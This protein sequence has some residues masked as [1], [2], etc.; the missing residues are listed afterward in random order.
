MR[1][2][3]VFGFAPFRLDLGSERLWREEEVVRLTAKAFAVLCY[4]VEQAGKLVT[5]DELF[6][7][8]WPET[9]VS[10][11]AL[12]VCIGEI[13]R[14]LGESAQSPRF[15]ET[16][17]GRGYRFLALV[18]LTLPAPAQ[19]LPQRPLPVV[20]LVTP[21]SLL[22]G[23]EAE[24]DRLQQCWTQAQQGTRQVV[25]V[26]GAAGI[27]KTTLVDALVARITD[28]HTIG[29][30]RGQCI[31][32]YGAGE[33]YLPLFEILG[34]L[35]QG[36]H[37]TRLVEVFTQY[38]P[39]WLLQMPAFLS[40][41]TMEALQ[42]HVGGT[43]RERMLRELA[44]AMETLTVDWPLLLV[45]EDL[46]WS[47]VSTLDWLAYM[48]RRRHPARLLVVGTYRPTE[49]MVQG[50]P[51]RTVT[52][53][54]ILHG[55]GVELRLGALS[56]ASIAAYLA[57]RFID[58]ELRKALVQAVYQRT[59]GHP[60]FLVTVV[61][62]LVRQGVLQP[63][64]ADREVMSDQETV[65]MDVPATIRQGI[66]L[67][68]ERC[69]PE[70]QTVLEAASVAGSEFTAAAVAASLAQ[71]DEAVEA[72]CDALVRHEQFLQALPPLDWPDGTVTA[73][74]RFRHDLYREILYERVPVSRRVQWH[75]QIG[76]RLEAGY[77]AQARALAAELAAH[78]VRGRDP[79][80]AVQYLQYAGEQA[81][82]R[83]AHQEA[84]R[85]FTQGLELLRTLPESPARARQELDLQLALGPTLM[86][87]KGQAAAEVEQAYTRARALCQQVGDTPRLFPTLWGLWR[88]YAERAR[89]QTSRDIGAQL[90]TLAQDV[91]DPVL[92][93]QAHHT[94]W[95]TL[96]YLGEFAQGRA[97]GEQGLAL[98]T[99]QPQRS[100]ALR[101]GG[102]DPGVCCY[103]YTAWTLW[104]L[105]YPEQARQWSTKALALAEELAHPFSLAHALS[106]TTV[107]YQFLRAAP[108]VQEHAEALMA[109]ATEQ[110]F[111][112]QGARG[113]LLRGWAFGS[114]G[115][116]QEG[117]EHLRQGLMAYQALGSERGIPYF[118]TLLAES[119]SNRG[120]TQEG[121]TALSQALEGVHKSEESFYLAEMYRLQGAL[122]LQQTH[123]PVDQ[124]T[125][126]LQQA[127]ASA[128]RQQAKSLELRAAISLARLWQRQGKRQDAY[129]LLAPLYG[130]F[131]EGFTSTDLLEAR[132]L[133]EELT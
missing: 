80:R 1:D 47:D 70:S 36:A 44:E 26:T 131:T 114:Q 24:L 41:T 48:A 66:T 19:E 59:E 116:A 42:R 103:N 7:A 88:F 79:E 120:Q 78:F 6:E 117:M 77:G 53:D 37:G 60:F 130:W 63:A 11:A 61:D 75:R 105:G 74:Y 101:Y 13:R 122:L 58:V 118:L 68:V 54:L 96:F 115:Q 82:Q 12:T 106:A 38:A 132:A 30:G 56:A 49:A 98:Y 67:Q 107:L 133:M 10:E 127:L 45:L 27:G 76:Q 99:P 71:T 94:L 57:R 85:H 87:V 21:P 5:K 39:G 100:Q 52:Q 8:V 104:A 128:R 126:C 119:Y 15:L 83:S 22:V 86:A 43:T 34:Q 108:L 18:T 89:H 102:H 3:R 112:L 32:Q 9:A 91:Q 14:A 40:E 121:L 69:A 110:G 62:E 51:V 93:L 84:L 23:R 33:A 95:P 124:A 17:R 113:M 65:L 50:H 73:C 46:H 20:S 123:P 28:P 125:V 64:S 4:L 16:V 109:L 55:Q 111:T 92:L 25:L 81:V 129:A 90:L 72:L 31:E 97:H 2:T 35:G 29:Y